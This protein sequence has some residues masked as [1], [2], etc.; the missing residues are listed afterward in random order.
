MVCSSWTRRAKTAS[1]WRGEPA[2]RWRPSRSLLSVVAF[3][4]RRFQSLLRSQPVLLPA[5]LDQLHG[6]GIHHDVG[7]PG[8]LVA[9]EGAFAG[10]VDADLAAPGEGRAAVVEDVEWA[11]DDDGVAAGVDVA[12]GAEGDLVEVVGV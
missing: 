6:G 10:G 9:V 1:D 5:P 2:L 8:A 7:G 4:G 12:E 3:I 11:V